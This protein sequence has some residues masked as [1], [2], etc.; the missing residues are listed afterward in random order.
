MIDAK[1]AAAID[2]AN[3]ELK[4]L[5]LQCVQ[6]MS[7]PGANLTC[8]TCFTST[9]V[10]ILPELKKL[11]L[12]CVQQM[13]APGATLTCFTCFTS[14]KVQI[15]PELK[16]LELQCVQQMSAPGAT[17]ACFTSTKVQICIYPARSGNSC[18]AV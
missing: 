12:Q 11:E 18:V 17:L 3:P 5:E 14:T 7:A 9:K 1:E 2:P 13:S 10:Q 15:L 16:K 8:F 6:Q 4:K